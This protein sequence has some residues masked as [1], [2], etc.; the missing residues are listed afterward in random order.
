[1]GDLFGVNDYKMSDLVFYIGLFGGIILT[2]RGLVGVVETGLF[3]LIIGAVVGIGLGWLLGVV[4]S[5][6]NSGDRTRED[7]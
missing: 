7:R 6:L 4:Y 5:A 2:Y 1:M 3:R